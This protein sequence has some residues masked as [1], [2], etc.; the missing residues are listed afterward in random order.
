[1]DPRLLD[2]LI[3]VASFLIFAALLVGLPYVLDAGAAYL[4]AIVIFIGVMACA[5]YIVKEKIT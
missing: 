1:M 2:V 3:G 5:G 4:V